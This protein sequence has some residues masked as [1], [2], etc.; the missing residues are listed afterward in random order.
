MPPSNILEPTS[1]DCG[2]LLYTRDQLYTILPQQYEFAQLDGFLHADIEAGT[3]AAYRDIREDEWWCRG[4]MP[5]QPIFPGV[6]MIESA[7]QICAF[8]VHLVF[9]DDTRIMGFGGIDNAKFRDSV[10][11]PARVIF[12]AQAVSRRSRKFVCDIQAFVEGKMVFEGRIT[13]MRLKIDH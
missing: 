7:A 12:V 10:Y 1:F 8:A 2:N 4:H 11:P 13:G 6:L 9:P 5:Q 3:F